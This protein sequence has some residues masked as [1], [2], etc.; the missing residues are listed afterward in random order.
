MVCTVTRLHMSGGWFDSCRGKKIFSIPCP[1]NPLF[2]GQWCSFSGN[3]AGRDED[4]P[5]LPSTA[6]IKNE[7][8]YTSTLPYAF[9]AWKAKTLPSLYLHYEIIWLKTTISWS[10]LSE[11]SHG[12][13]WQIKWN[14][15][16]KTW[17][18]P[19]AITCKPS[20]IIDHENQDHPT[21]FGGHFQCQITR[22]SNQQ[23]MIW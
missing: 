9:L 1:C 17:N 11:F 16:G 10:F 12:K 20:L 4:D 14:D 15:Y 2:N 18:V 7:C 21:T 22:K 13:L 8:R 19:H 5:L 6:Y 23:I 3:K